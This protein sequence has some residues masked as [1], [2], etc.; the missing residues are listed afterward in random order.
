ME[1]SPETPWAPASVSVSRE[2]HEAGT[3]VLPPVSDHRI[4]VHASP[5]TWSFC[6]ITGTRHLRREGD[7]DLVP[8]GEEGGHAAETA[9]EALEIRLAP[10]VL[11]QAAFEMGSGRRS[12]LDMR[13]IMKNERIVYMA[14]AL[15]SERRAG[16]PSGPL[17]ADTIGVALATQLVGL[18]KPAANAASGLSAAQL[19][20]LYDFVEA[21]ID[22]P[23]T[24]GVL[25]RVAGASSSHL[26]NAF[27]KATG[28]TVHRFV[29][30]RRVE[31]ARLMLAQGRLSAAEVA[32]AAG[33]SHQSHMARWMRR[34]LG[35]TPRSLRA[36]PVGPR[37]I[38][39]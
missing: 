19:R 9:Y 11:E 28:S 26:R 10:Q 18:T 13:H 3:I 25:A 12:G 1:G 15:E 6:T 30:R 20:R 35:Q 27:K 24:I 38:A 23:L 14:L 17:Y 29:V 2:R 31:R 7:I 5:E 36:D 21:H 22:R 16:A 33:F 37:S 39:P 34:E 32:L 4:V 8:A